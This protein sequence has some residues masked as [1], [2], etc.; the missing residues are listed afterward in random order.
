MPTVIRRITTRNSED[1]SE[2]P[3]VAPLQ[4]LIPNQFSGSGRTHVIRIQPNGARQREGALRPRFSS[5]SGL[6]DT[7]ASFRLDIT[8]GDWL[9][10]RLACRRPGLGRPCSSAPRPSHWSSPGGRRPAPAA[11]PQPLR[12]SRPPP[13]PGRKARWPWSRRLRA[14]LADGKGLFCGRTDLA[15]DVKVCVVVRR[16]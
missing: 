7:S 12:S 3:H 9:L 4:V 1:E 10:L 16:R 11:P 6:T 13:P 5:C 8:L 15:A 2:F 14:T